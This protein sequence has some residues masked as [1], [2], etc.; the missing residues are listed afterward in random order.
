MK[1]LILL[2]LAGFA[3]AIPDVR[4]RVLQ[5]ALIVLLGLG[6]H[7]AKAGAVVAWDRHNNLTTAY[8]GPVQKETTR[9]LETAR[10]KGWAQ[11]TIITSSD[12]VG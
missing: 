1:K 5:L 10:R 8:G 7:N 4:R 2:A 9:A 11:S 3:V 6:L 12:T